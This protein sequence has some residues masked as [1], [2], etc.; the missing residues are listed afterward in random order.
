M[1]EFETP[2]ALKL[3]VSDEAGEVRVE[4]GAAGRTEVELR[5]I[6]AAS[7][8]QVEATHVDCRE[9]GDGQRVI[10]DVPSPRRGFLFG[11]YGVDVLVRVPEGTSLEIT[12]S[13]A[14]VRAEGQY[15]TGLIRTVS[16]D[17]ELARFTGNLSVTTASGDVHV[18][19]ALASLQVRTASGDIDVERA[20]GELSLEAQSG[21]ISVR[22]A[23]GDARLRGSSSEVQVWTAAGNLDVRTSSGDVMVHELLAGGS[24]ATH[25]GDA[26]LLSVLSGKVT[27]ETMSGDVEVGIAPGSRVAVDTETRSGD[28]RSEIALSDSVESVGGEGPKVALEVRTMSGDISLRRGRTIATSA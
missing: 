18:A 26:E 6:S 10:V 17:A 15:A 12:T 23:E 7:Q 13:S 25:S 24:I 9:D 28:V 20:K 2:R 1:Y 3:Q 19:E 21:D 4:T 8:A 27:V 14:D 5:A 11:N 16:G 22:A